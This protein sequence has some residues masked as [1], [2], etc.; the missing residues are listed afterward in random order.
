LRRN[1]GKGTL[2]ESLRRSHGGRIIEKESWR[3]Y[4]RRN[5]G[6]GVIE[7]ESLMRNH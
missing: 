4:L 6:G 3:E 5:H 7:A 1:L 2:E